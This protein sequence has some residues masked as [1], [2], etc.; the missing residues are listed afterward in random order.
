MMNSY[1]VRV[2]TLAI[3]TGDRLDVLLNAHQGAIEHH[4]VS[5]RERNAVGSSGW[6]HH[7]DPWVRCALEAVDDVSSFAGA[8]AA[9]DALVGNVVLG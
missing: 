1:F 7:Q 9:V 5:S 4:R 8:H 6:L 3:S 2:L